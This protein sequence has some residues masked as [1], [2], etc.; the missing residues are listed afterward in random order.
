MLHPSV[1]SAVESGP[2][3]IRVFALMPRIG[4]TKNDPFDPSQTESASAE[5]GK[6]AKAAAALPT[7]SGASPLG[8]RRED[9]VCRAEAQAGRALTET[10]TRARAVL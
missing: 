4:P 5:Q 1:E 7:F 6:G 10:M 9:G 3:A 8:F 2:T